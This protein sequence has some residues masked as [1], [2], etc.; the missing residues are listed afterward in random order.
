[1]PKFLKLSAVCERYGGINACTVYRQI[2][3]GRFPAAHKLGTRAL[4]AVADLDAFDKC[5]TAG[6]DSARSAA[7]SA[8]RRKA[9]ATEAQP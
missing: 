4:W 1:M 5:L 2:R 3:A 9:R 7:A 6:V 8:K